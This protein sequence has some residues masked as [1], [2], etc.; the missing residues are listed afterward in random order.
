MAKYPAPGR[1][2]T[3]L[4]AELGDDTACALQR[5][6]LLDL[7]DRLRALPY[8]VTWA[9][10]PPS[11]PFATLIGGGRCRA[12]SGEDLGARMAAAV[13][14]ELADGGGPVVVLGADVPHVDLDCIRRAVRALAAD[15]DVVLGPALDGGYYLIGLRAVA[16]ALFENIAW[17]TGRVL[18]AT[19]AQAERL[20]LRV[21]LVAESFDVD[22]VAD[23]ARLRAVMTAPGMDLPRTRVVL[24]RLPIRP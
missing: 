12:Q 14:A 23:L 7:A 1:V 4:A 13:E 15:V 16:P 10:W 24:E 3:R 11:A 21:E 18:R 5:A 19:L 22:Q 8:G 20:G 2:K 17:G 9:F 6:F